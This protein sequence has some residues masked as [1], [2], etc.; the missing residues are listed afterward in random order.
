MMM[1]ELYC[2]GYLCCACGFCH[3]GVAAVVLECYT[4]IPT[5]F[6]AEVARVSCPYLFVCDDVTPKRP[7][8]CCVVIKW[9]MEV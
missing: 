4:H 2:V 6:T 8:G 1:L 7:D 5:R 9:A 3:D